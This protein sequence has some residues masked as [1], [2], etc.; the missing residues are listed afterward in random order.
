ATESTDLLH[1]N[2]PLHPTATMKFTA[3]LATALLGFT[4]TA[5]LVE[6]VKRD[7]EEAQDNNVDAAATRAGWLYIKRDG[8]E[9]QDNNVDAAATRA[10]WLYIKRDG[11][12]AQD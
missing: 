7:V 2:K 9:A 1:S 5:L 8:Q 3:A 12:E 6:G 11:Q 4:V 10:G